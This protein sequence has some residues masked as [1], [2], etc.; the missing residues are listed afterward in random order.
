LFFYLR[1]LVTTRASPSRYA[2]GYLQRLLQLIGK[3]AEA[4]CSSSVTNYKAQPATATLR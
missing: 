3:M 1:L 4:T 2:T